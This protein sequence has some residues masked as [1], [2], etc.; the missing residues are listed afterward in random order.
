[1]ATLSEGSVGAKVREVGQ[2]EASKQHRG[3]LQQL[4]NH[5]PQQAQ[6]RK[7]TELLTD[8]NYGKPVHS[9]VV[10]YM[11]AKVSSRSDES[12]VDIDQMQ[13]LITN[14]K[15]SAQ[16]SREL[17][18]MMQKPM[19]QKYDQDNKGHLTKAEV[20]TMLMELNKGRPVEEYVVEWVFEESDI[21]DNGVITLF[22]LPR[23]V[24]FWECRKS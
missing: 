20:A 2:G 17:E 3:P 13:T 15:K 24:T 7:V 10:R 21:L 5:E 11:M 6:P 8:L 18:P 4:R 16:R 19:M 22:E 9:D 14:F 1:M 12:T 23:V